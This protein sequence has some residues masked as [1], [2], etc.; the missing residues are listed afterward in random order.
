MAARQ[1][2]GVASPD[3]LQGEKHS[4][5]YHNAFLIQRAAGFSPRSRYVQDIVPVNVRSTFYE[6]D[7]LVDRVHIG[8]TNVLFMLFRHQG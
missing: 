8:K 3:T 1:T 5:F 6:P 7:F 4:V 2:G